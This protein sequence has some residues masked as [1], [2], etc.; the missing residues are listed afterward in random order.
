MKEKLVKNLDLKILAVLLSVVLW[1]VVVNID[2]PVKNVQFSDVP[3]TILN[4]ELLKEKGL[5]YDIIDESNLINVSVS[6]RRSV[7]EEL[8]K[9]DIIA[10]A[11]VKDLKDDNTIDIKL[12]SNKYSADIDGIKSDEKFVALNVEELRKTQKSIQV[13]ITGEPAAGYLLG[14]ASPS[15]NMVEISGPASAIGNVASVKAI[16]DVEG[17]MSSINAN[18]PL[19]LYDTEGKLISDSRIGMNINSISVSQEI[20]A[21]KNVQLDFVIEGEPADGYLASGK[22]TSD[23]TYVTIAGKKGLIDSI[24]SIKVVDDAL[25][26]AGAKGPITCDINLTD[27]IPV[28]TR[29]VGDGQ[30]KT[31]V[32]VVVDVV[33]EAFLNVSYDVDSVKID[34]VPSGLKAE[35]V[36]DGRYIRNGLNTIKVYGLP[37]D[38]SKVNDDLNIF[39][40]IETYMSDNGMT[41]LSKGTYWV[42]PT[43]NLPGSVHFNQEFKVQIKVY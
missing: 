18:A 11:D 1:L 25:N 20:L 17:V 42:E 27:Y 30:N 39:V 41:S 32:R 6:G 3:V 36:A 22:V 2:D 31:K 23:V 9:G 13:E 4:D 35:A 40:D 43:F 14:D 33:R 19:R 21:T 26:I 8:S 34:G 12:S 5:V 10:T 28:G 29:I 7:I 38:I 15:L 24:G 16:I 37:D